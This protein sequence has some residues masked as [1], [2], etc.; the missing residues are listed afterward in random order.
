VRRP[1]VLVSRIIDR[2]LR[3]IFPP[4]FCREVQIL[5]TVLGYDPTRNC[6]PMAM[7][8]S[9]AAL[10]ASPIPYDTPVAGVAVGMD[11]DGRFVVNPSRALLKTSRL[12]LFVSGTES[13]VMMI[14]GAADFLTEEEMAEAIEV[15]MQVIKQICKGLKEFSAKTLEVRGQKKVTELI[16]KVD[17]TLFAEFEEKLAEDM[18]AACRTGKSSKSDVYSA[19]FGL[20]KK[21][22]QLFL[23]DAPDA[24]RE[25]DIKTTFKRFAAERMRLLAKS[26]G[27]RV[28][29]RTLE[30]VRPLSHLSQDLSRSAES[31]RHSVRSPKI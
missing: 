11:A 4:G 26:E 25:I 8:A 31:L 29:G 10:L 13:S 27:L 24:G 1:Q 21:A 19:V 9:A 7:V 16:R 12:N 15:G 5:T 14:E 28:D 23:G 20:E 22:K 3:P 18:D 30:Q 2:T 6:D 17:T